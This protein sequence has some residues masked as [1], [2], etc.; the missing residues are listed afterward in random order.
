MS[1]CLRAV[2][3]MV[4]LALGLLSGPIPAVAQETA[5]VEPTD[6]DAGGLLGAVTDLADPLVRIKATQV[7]DGLVRGSEWA[8]LHV[9]LANLGEPLV[10]ELIVETRNGTDTR[11]YR[12]EVELPAG[13]RKTVRLLYKPGL[14]GQTR[15]VDFLAGR[16]SVAAEVP[17]RWVSQDEVAIGVIGEDAVGLPVVRTTWS[18]RVPARAPMPDLGSFAQGDSRTVHVGLIPEAQVPDRANGLDVFNWLVW[19]DADPTALA[20][21]QLAALRAWVA[22]GGHLLLTVTERWRQVGEGP[23]ADVLPVSLTGVRDGQGAAK[24]LGR[25]GLDDAPQ[26]TARLRRVPGRRAEVL[27]ETED[28]DAIWTVGTYGLGTVH[29]LAVDPRVEPLRSG[30]DRERLWRQLL[31]L[32]PQGATAAWFYLGDR[33]SGASQL[34]SRATLPEP[35]LRLHP[36]L[37]AAMALT[38]PVSTA[39]HGGYGGTDGENVFGDTTDN[40]FSVPVDF[41][42]DIPGV[43]PIPMGWLLAFAAVYLM[44]IGPLDYIVLRL[45][46][47]QTLTWITFP[48]SI[49]VFSAL[50][51][52]GT[53]Y[54]KG[55]QAVVTRYEI[56][57]L[58]PG[59]NLWRGTSWYGVWS[60]RGT[61]L[62]MTSGEDDGIA[63][64]LVDSGY[65]KDVQIVHGTGGSALQWGAD[66]WTLAYVRTVWT[67][68]REGRFTAVALGDSSIEL[69]NDTD[70]DLTNVIVDMDGVRQTFPSFPAGTTLRASPNGVSGNRA[71]EDYRSE[72][73]ELDDHRSWAVTNAVDYPEVRRGHLDWDAWDVIVVGATT[74]PIEDSVLDGLTPN[75]RTLT[76]VRVPLLLQ[77]SGS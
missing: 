35:D 36:D 1:H 14:G 52:L 41:L 74:G 77:T 49:A 17:M 67:A 3:L 26:A 55:S 50:A 27:V 11:R 20:P 44:V 34:G 6:T 76:V 73:L 56:V 33:R 48:V 28:G 65:Q 58:L 39:G 13:A 75:P 10:G 60:T 15:R 12:R 47:R 32:P 29:V 70:L 9:D 51:L 43:A 37:L 54:V 38:A 42:E 66:T 23:L 25:P 63:E 18:G 46:R 57:D 61:T 7:G 4:L 68:P 21:E 30:L 2:L 5:P 53:S 69:R 19:V 40:W 22:G 31:W 45:L 71:P 8:A 62:T 59:T 16:R 72:V 64:A 24:L